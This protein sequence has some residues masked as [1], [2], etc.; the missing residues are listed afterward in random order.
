MYVG[1][2]D[3]N[4]YAVDA[5]TGREQWRFSTAGKIS[6]SPVVIDGVIYFGGVDARLD[7]SK[8]GALFALH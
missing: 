4:L 1:S 3:G 6:S 5:A 2:Y 7:G 8:R